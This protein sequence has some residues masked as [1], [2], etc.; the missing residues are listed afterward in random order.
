MDFCRDGGARLVDD[1]VNLFDDVKVSL[2]VGV[3]HA[4]PTPRNVGQLTRRQSVA[5]AEKRL[6]RYTPTFLQ[7][8]S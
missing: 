8:K 3:L 7:H 5:D 4:G 6:E 1:G 2:V